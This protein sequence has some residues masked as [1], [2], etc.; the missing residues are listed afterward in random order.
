MGIR[1]TIDPDFGW[2]I[3]FGELVR[4]SKSTW[5]LSIWKSQLVAQQIL[6]VFVIYSWH[7]ASSCVFCRC[8]TVMW[9]SENRAAWVGPCL[10]SHQT[11][12]QLFEAQCE[13]QEMLRVNAN[14]HERYLSG[15]C[16]PHTY[17]FFFGM[18]KMG[19][20]TAPRKMSVP[21]VFS[22]EQTFVFLGKP[23]LQSWPW[24]NRCPGSVG[25]QDSLV[26]FPRI[27][28]NHRK[29]QGSKFFF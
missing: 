6:M 23:W 2:T 29:E 19:M 15:R 7:L 26:C 28:W 21:C 18:K 11:L 27:L 8:N 16:F 17:L 10:Y 13:K 3:R 4:D 1:S 14:L 25:F 22:V 5:C 24:R 12:P 20:I 9:E